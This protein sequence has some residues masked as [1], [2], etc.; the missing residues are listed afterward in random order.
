MINPPR[1]PVGC[2]CG[3][4]KR[5]ERVTKFPYKSAVITIPPSNASTSLR[6]VIIILGS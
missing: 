5:I 3:K 6:H 2:N 1:H 4:A